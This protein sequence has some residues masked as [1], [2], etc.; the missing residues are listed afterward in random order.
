[1]CWSVVRNP[2][3][4]DSAVGSSIP[5]DNG[6]RTTDQP[7]CGGSRPVIA[8]GDE[9]T[10]AA[11]DSSI[12][13]ARGP[14]VKNHITHEIPAIIIARTSVSDAADDSIQTGNMA[15]GPEQRVERV[16]HVVRNSFRTV[17][18]S[19][20]MPFSVTKGAHYVRVTA[21]VPIGTRG[22]CRWQGPRVAAGAEASRP[23][24]G[25]PR[26]ILAGQRPRNAGNRPTGRCRSG[27]TVSPE[28]ARQLCWLRSR[29]TG[30]WSRS[31]GST[32]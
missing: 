18:V 22:P 32:P 20:E 12:G 16:E 19:C 7:C 3:S 21:K 10:R 23:R 24:M 11:D 25:A 1:V 29:K 13:H 6:R 15:H 5:T 30:G 4:V 2:L 26:R 27:W 31:A 17:H 14:A 8:P 28:V 9:P